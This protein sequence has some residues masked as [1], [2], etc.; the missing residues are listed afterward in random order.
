MQI[1][2]SY[3]LIATSALPLLTSAHLYMNMPGV[4]R[5]NVDELPPLNANGADFPCGV[6]NFDSKQGNG[7]TLTPGQNNQGVIQLFGTAVHGGGSCQVS[8]TYDS[9]PKKNSVWK[10]MKS[11]EGGCPMDTDGN[12]N[13]ALGLNNKLPELRYTVP[14][15]LPGG[16]ATIAWTWF[17]RRGQR[18]MYMRCQSV[19]INSNTRNRG[20]F[21]R[22][23]DMFVANIR[24]ENQ[25]STTEGGNLK[26][27]QPGSDKRGNG[28]S[29]PVGR[30][31]VSK[32]TRER[33]N[34][35][36]KRA[37]RIARSLLEDVDS[38]EEASDIHGLAQDDYD[39][40][41]SLKRGDE[42][43]DDESRKWT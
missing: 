40:G 37:L 28:N 9:P 19:S 7:P 13:P 21:D 26:F 43:E 33:K 30:D 38:H 12:L 24:S 5:N 11:F 39:I 25:C 2:V 14:S 34:R 10:V 27:P 31:C 16:Q 3:V 4:Y 42:F 18:E 29:A 15:G 35:K 41:R 6:R 22:L 36:M 20:A 32:A 17:N 23:P 8:I 1:S